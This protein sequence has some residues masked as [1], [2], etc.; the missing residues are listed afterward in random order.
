MF[1]LPD[2]QLGQLR[3]LWLYWIR[4]WLWLYWIRGLTATM[5]ARLQFWKSRS[6][7]RT[8]EDAVSAMK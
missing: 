6:D 5:R 7:S 4:L 2:Q 3:R 1:G 8:V